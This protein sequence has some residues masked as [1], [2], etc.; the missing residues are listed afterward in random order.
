MITERTYTEYSGSDIDNYYLLQI[1]T[2]VLLSGKT[3]IGL[4]DKNNKE[5]HQLVGLSETLRTP[6]NL[7]IAQ[8]LNMS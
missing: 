2:V 1:I 4:S 6:L 3:I 5:A 8:I 7:K